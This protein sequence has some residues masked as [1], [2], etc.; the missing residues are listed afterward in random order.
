[1]GCAKNNEGNY[2]MVLDTIEKG[3]DGQIE[4]VLK[5]I[6]NKQVKIKV[7]ADEAP[8]EFFFVH[9]KNIAPSSL[10]TRSACASML[11]TS[12]IFFIRQCH[13]QGLIRNV[14]KEDLEKHIMTEKAHTEIR[15]LMTTLVPE[16]LHNNGDCQAA[17]LWKLVSRVRNN[18][19]FNF[20]INL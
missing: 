18:S 10:R 5:N 17:Y 4:F 3:G 19:D 16:P 20:L 15:N 9:I 13:E 8:E 2:A 14:T 7:D 1:M 12:C 6:V 11:Q